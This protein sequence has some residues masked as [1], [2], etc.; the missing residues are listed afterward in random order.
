MQ[1]YVSD[2][3]RLPPPGTPPFGRADLELEDVEKSGASFVLDVFVGNPKATARTTRDI[4]HGFAGTLPVFAHGDCWGDYGHCDTPVGPQ[5]PFDHRP[6]HP[7]IPVNLSLEVTAA[8]QFLGPIEEV[9]VT[10]LAFERDPSIKARRNIL[11]FGRLTLV[12]YD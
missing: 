2:P 1:R 9:V 6:P 4:T 12:T 7:L 3:L 5:D 11:R 10:I 8:L